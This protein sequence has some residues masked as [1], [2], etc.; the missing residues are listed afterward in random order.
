[1]LQ[2]SFKTKKKSKTCTPRA[3]NNLHRIGTPRR[4]MNYGIEKFLNFKIIF[5]RACFEK[6]VFR[7]PG[8]TALPWR[9]YWWPMR[10]RT[11]PIE[12]PTIKNLLILKLIVWWLRLTILTSEDWAPERL[13]PRAQKLNR[14]QQSFRLIVLLQ[15]NELVLN[16]FVNHGMPF[17]RY[18]KVVV[19]HDLHLARCARAHSRI[20]LRSRRSEYLPQR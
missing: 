16:F 14:S 2:N 17:F 18:G 4:V 11:D 9:W 12:S 6:T 13:E 1:M 8:D 3:N 19:R 20:Q 10:A 15:Q 7:F 5:R